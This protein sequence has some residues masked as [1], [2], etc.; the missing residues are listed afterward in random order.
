MGSARS[1]RFDA[2][3]QRCTG[4]IISK[5]AGVTQWWAALSVASRCRKPLAG[6]PRGIVGGKENGDAG[7]VCGLSDATKR[8]ACE[9]RLLKIAAYDA[10][11]VCAFGLD[12]ARRYGVHPDLSRTQLRGEPT[13]DG[14]HR[15]FRPGIDRCL[16]APL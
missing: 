1:C 13:C 11:A 14:I 16:R 4:A 12:F 15:P 3:C 5:G 8:R 9:H 2:P 6:E 7:N 10:G